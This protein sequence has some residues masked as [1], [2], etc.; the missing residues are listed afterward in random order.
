MGADDCLHDLKAERQMELAIPARFTP[1]RATPATAGELVA[2]DAEDRERARREL[3][4]LQEGLVPH[5]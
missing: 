4:R 1:E 2:A 5:E 3:A